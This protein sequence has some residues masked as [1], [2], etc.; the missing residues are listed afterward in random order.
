LR[1]LFALSLQLPG[2]IN[3]PYQTVLNLV[4]LH[5]QLHVFILTQEPI[6]LQLLVLVLVRLFENGF[7]S[8][9]Q[10]LARLQLHQLLSRLVVLGDRGFAGDS[11]VEGELGVVVALRGAS[12][13]RDG[14]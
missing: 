8:A 1:F 9:R 2:L 5:G 12:L 11:H 10:V 3:N 14:D 4:A 6:G 13:F 7:E